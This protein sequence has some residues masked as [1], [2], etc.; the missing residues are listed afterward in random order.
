M[1]ATDTANVLYG[2]MTETEVRDKFGARADNVMKRKIDQGQT[3]EDDDDGEM[4]YWVKRVDESGTKVA[5]VREQGVK[6]TDAGARASGSG[7]KRELPR[8]PA[9]TVYDSPPPRKRS[10]SGSPPP[11]SQGGR[12][13]SAAGDN[14]RAPAS[15]VGGAIQALGR[16]DRKK[17]AKRL[18]GDAPNL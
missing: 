18:P 13:A 11:A 14:K 1:I 8:S 4:R 15:T 5:H 12:A 17:I 6:C 7:G 10:T 2:W 16:E 9:K 3:K